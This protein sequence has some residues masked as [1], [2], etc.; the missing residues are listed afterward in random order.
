MNNNF[1]EFFSDVVQR[2]Y[3]ISCLQFGK[4]RHSR[5][6]EIQVGRQQNIINIV[7]IKLTL[8]KSMIVFDRKFQFGKQYVHYPRG[9]FL[10]TQR[11]VEWTRQAGEIDWQ[12]HLRR[13]RPFAQGSSNTILKSRRRRRYQILLVR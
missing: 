8:T 2:V 7:F 12:R 1:L 3:S 9:P 6:G 4:D 13:F 11:H 10:D 5:N